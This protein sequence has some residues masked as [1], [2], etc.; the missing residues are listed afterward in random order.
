[1]KVTSTES[2]EKKANSLSLE[3]ADKFITLKGSKR[4]ESLFTKPFL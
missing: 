4:N 2:D 3:I 1:M